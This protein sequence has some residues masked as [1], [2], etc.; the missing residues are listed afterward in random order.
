MKRKNENHANDSPRRLSRRLNRLQDDGTPVRNSA[1]LNDTPKK[2]TSL[3]NDNAGL[4][5]H[6]HPLKSNETHSVGRSSARRSISNVS[7]KHKKSQ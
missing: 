6:P 5:L 1:R 7:N 3:M 4:I 2:S